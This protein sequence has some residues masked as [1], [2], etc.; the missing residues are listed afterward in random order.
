MNKKIVLL[1]AV[2]V[3]SV[4]FLSGCNEDDSGIKKI[5]S[6]KDWLEFS[7]INITT[8]WQS[9]KTISGGHVRFV[10]HKESGFYHNIS[11]DGFSQSTA[12]YQIKGKVKNVYGDIINFLL[13]NIVL[14][15]K[16]GNKLCSSDI[17]HVISDLPNGYSES[18][19]MMVLCTDYFEYAE[20]YKF[21][22]G[23]EQ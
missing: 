4:G 14:Y 13:I 11:K 9:K 10:D 7:D 22:V 18:F 23:E 19:S 5:G 17:P 21:L 20:D 8:H 3:V 2:L 12:Y 1:I 15:D 16:E 6:E